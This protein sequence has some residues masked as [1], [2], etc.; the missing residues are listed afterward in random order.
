MNKT[1]TGS[2]GGEAQEGSN[3]GA[4]GDAPRQTP[5][6]GKQPTLQKANAATEGL[7]L[8]QWVCSGCASE[9][10]ER[11]EGSHPALQK[12]T[13]AVSPRKQLDVVKTKQ[14]SKSGAPRGL[15]KTRVQHTHTH[16]D[17]E[18][19]NLYCYQC[20]NKTCGAWR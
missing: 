8:H 1:S 4:L 5:A 13:D 12:G 9:K 20:C 17:P 2:L 7:S 3:A 11:A 15:P 16:K 6:V 19:L 10:G 18:S 14:F